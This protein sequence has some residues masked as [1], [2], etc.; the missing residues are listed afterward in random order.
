M[1]SASTDKATQ[2]DAATPYLFQKIRQKEGSYLAVP[3]VSSENRLYMP[4]GFLDANI[5]CGDNLFFI[6]NANLYHFGILC[7]TF[8]NA[9]IRAVCGRLESV[10]VTQ[11][12]SSTTISP[13]RMRVKN[14]SGSLPKLPRPCLTCGPNS[15]PVPGMAVQP[16]HHA[17]QTQQSPR[18]PG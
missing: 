7:S 1:R 11:T 17:G 15:R 16:G 12:P 9:W 4:I 6:V 2:K 5:I 18:P 8:H 14:K 13:G 10:I 3:K